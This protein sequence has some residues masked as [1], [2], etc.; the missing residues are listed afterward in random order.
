MHRRRGGDPLDGSSLF[1]QRVADELRRAADDVRPERDL[2]DLQRKI[3]RRA[4]PRR[5]WQI[6]RRPRRRLRREARSV[7][8]PDTDRIP[9][10]SAVQEVWRASLV[11]RP[12]ETRRCRCG[13]PMLAAGWCCWTCIAAHDGGWHLQAYNPHSP[14]WFDMHT[15]GCERRTAQLDPV[16]A[17]LGA[18]WNA[19][20]A[21]REHP[22]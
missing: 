7:P 6:W 15:E 21:R 18:A 17:Y 22:R 11:P 14:N 16:A 12:G 3:A 2:A 5:W 1:E 10:L 4:R 9:A 19:G 8:D 13:R 20:S